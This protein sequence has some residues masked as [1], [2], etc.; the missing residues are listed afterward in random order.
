MLDRRCAAAAQRRLLGAAAAAVV[1]EDQRARGRAKNAE[2]VEKARALAPKATQGNLFS[3]PLEEGTT[4]AES[5]EDVFGSPKKESAGKLATELKDIAAE[6][7]T[8]KPTAFDTYFDEVM[9]EPVD[10][11]AMTDEQVALEAER[12]ALRDKVN[13]KQEA[14]KEDTEHIAGTEEAGTIGAFFD[15]IRPTANTA[16]EKTKHDALKQTGRDL[17]IEYDLAKPGEKTTPGMQ[18]ALKYL[19]RRVGGQAKLSQLIEDLR[20]PGTQSQSRIL[21]NA[22][23]PDLTTRRGMEQF[24]DELKE[25]QTNYA[26]EAG[27]VKVPFGK[28]PYVSEATTV[29]RKT[30]ERK[31]SPEGKARRPMTSNESKRY[32]ISD[33]KLRSAWNFLTACRS[34][35]ITRTL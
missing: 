35:S 33:N 7:E 4:P 23:L 24:N 3:K 15:A 28:L 6:V 12:Q 19:A 11:S 2:A 26:P 17:L 14:P 27:G 10:E 32:E 34:A 30:V 13:E 8:E 22:N 20:T 16:S 18:K 21:E 25:F 31:P 5:M 29:T 9:Y 1:A